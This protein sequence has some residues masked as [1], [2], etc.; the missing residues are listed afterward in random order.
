MTPLIA[1]QLVGAVYGLRQRAAC[2]AR[3][4]ELAALSNICVLTADID[5]VELR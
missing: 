4:R 5:I 2:R 3:E 1:I